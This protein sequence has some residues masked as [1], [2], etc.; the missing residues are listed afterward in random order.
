MTPMFL[1]RAAFCLIAFLAAQANASGTPPPR[2][3]PAPKNTLYYMI[4][5]NTAIL[6]ELSSTEAAEVPGSPGEICSLTSEWKMEEYEIATMA[7]YG[8]GPFWFFKGLDIS[9]FVPFYFRNF[10]NIEYLNLTDVGNEAA[11]AQATLHTS[12]RQGKPGSGVGDVGISFMTLFYADPSTRTW[13]SGALKLVMP[14][15]P[16]SGERF[17]RILHGD[18]LAP[19]GGGGV[20]RLIPAISGVK[21]V[22]GQRAYADLEYIIPLGAERFSFRSP[23]LVH[24]NGETYLDGGLLFDEKIVHGGILLFTMG[25]ETNLDLRGIV[26]AVEMNFRQ[27]RA[28]EWTEN[29]ISGLDPASAAYYNLPTPFT[30]YPSHTP[31]F[32]TDAAWSIGNLP[33]KN[34]SEIEL[35]IMGTW[36]IRPTD[37]VKAGVSFIFN[38]FGSAWSLKLSFT[39]LF[40][41]KTEAE[42]EA[43]L[44]GGIR[45]REIEVSPVIG[46][47]PAPSSDLS[48]V[49]ALPVYELGVSQEE[50]AW[51]AEELRNEVDFLK[52]YRVVP[53]SEMAQLAQ[54]PCGDAKCGA[55]YGRA[56]KADAIIVSRLSKTT[57]GFFF[58]ALLINVSNGEAVSSA[59][60]EGENLEALADQL[61]YLLDRLTKTPE[62]PGSGK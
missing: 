46:A 44:S 31:G 43:E 37:I 36:R 2:Y 39:N 35:G 14:T 34:N 7:G 50:A 4:F 21:S 19:G 28:A 10:E 33:L 17:T 12:M 26:P 61:P 20:F 1:S 45:A 57:K 41:E 3:L 9:L 58:G 27:Y 62:T 55:Q 38:N 8:L 53:A 59:T 25:M 54:L 16:S 56:L 23:A 49:T 24:Q 47:P 6:S 18:D 51:V 15:S 60:A 11:R 40:I 5:G 52:G 32:L 48:V 13:G 42:L 29:G 22:A 30:A